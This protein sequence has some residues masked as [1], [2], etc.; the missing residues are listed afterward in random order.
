MARAAVGRCGHVIPR[1]ARSGAAV[2]AAGAVGGAGKRAVID[3]GPAPSGCLVARAAVGRCR[4]VISRFARSGAAVVAAGTVGRTGKGTVI[5]FGATPHV[6][7]M[8]KVSA[9][10]KRCKSMI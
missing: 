3:L 5:N 10:K 9:F 4:H 1:F 2:V 7:L 6:G 8:T